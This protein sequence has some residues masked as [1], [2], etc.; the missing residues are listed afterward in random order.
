M[1]KLLSV[2]LL[3]T[4]VACNNPTPEPEYDLTEFYAFYQKFHRDSAFQMSRIRFPLEGFPNHAGM[5]STVNR[6]ET[7]YW[8]SEDWVMHKPIDFEMSEFRRNL[9]PVTEDLIFERIVHKSG[10]Y[11]MERK[12]AKLSDGWN[13]IYYVGMNRMKSGQ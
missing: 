6:T 12:W 8:E 3:I 13:L 10:H 7:F 5:D 1:N 2:F 11:G 9:V 4:F